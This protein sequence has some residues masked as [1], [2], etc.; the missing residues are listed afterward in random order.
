MPRGD[1]TKSRR[2]PR[3]RR[4]RPAPGK[5]PVL[6]APEKLEAIG[7]TWRET[8]KTINEADEPR[9]AAEEEEKAEEV[10]IK[11]CPYSKFCLRYYRTREG[12][13]LEE[14]AE[15]FSATVAKLKEFNHLD[16][17]DLPAGRMLRIP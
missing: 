17:T 14:I 4:N 7:E 1:P 11:C 10:E 15:R 8:I 13:E 2:K 12:D 6:A 3:N 9:T 5:P 16:S